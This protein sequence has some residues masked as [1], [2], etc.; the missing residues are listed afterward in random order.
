VASPREPGERPNRTPLD[1]APGERYRG[2]TAADADAGA[3]RDG[4]GPARGVARA[5][6]VGIAGA[7]LIV[8]FGGA[9]GVS[10]GLVVLAVVIGR[11]VTLALLAGGGSTI[12]PGARTA[13]AVGTAI[14]AILLG[15]LGIWL[16]ARSEGGVLGPLD[17]LAQA[18]GWLVPLQLAVAALVAG[19]T[20][21]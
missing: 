4:S 12:R 6:L 21:R 13:I 10:L 15:Q 14:L 2:G 20:S 9:L 11:F 18:F 7:A 3:S 19:W 8:V 17:Y 1:R 5:V 16:Y